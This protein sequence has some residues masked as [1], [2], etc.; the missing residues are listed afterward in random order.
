MKRAT[1]IRG[2]N[3]QFPNVKADSTHNY[4]KAL[5]FYTLTAA[6]SKPPSILKRQ[7]VC[8]CVCVRAR[9]RA[10]PT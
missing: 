7:C 8:V 4:H 3:A 5:N 2:R 6:L 10:R 9:A 1:T